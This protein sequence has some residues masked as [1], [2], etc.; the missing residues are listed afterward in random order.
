METISLCIRL[1]TEISPYAYGH[2]TN[3]RMHTGISVILSPYACGDLQYPH[4]RTG[5][6]SSDAFGPNWVWQKE[7]F[8]TFKI[9]FLL[10]IWVPSQRSQ[11]RRFRIKLSLTERIVPYLFQFERKSLIGTSITKEKRSQRIQTKQILTAILSGGD[12]FIATQGK[13][14]DPSETDPH[15]HTGTRRMRTG[16]KA[17]NFAYGKSPFA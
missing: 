2:L 17:G 16:R 11:V 15:M 6:V 13:I 10:L 3:P 7:L 1:V 5:E 8:L 14:A 4:I 12:S 9:I